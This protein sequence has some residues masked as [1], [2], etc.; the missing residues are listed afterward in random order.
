VYPHYNFHPERLI[1]ETSA[2][3][4]AIFGPAKE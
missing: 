4:D 1:F 2:A 3:I